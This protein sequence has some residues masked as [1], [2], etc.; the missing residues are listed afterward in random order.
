MNQWSTAKIEPIDPG[1][2]GRMDGVGALRRVIT[3][4][5]ASTRLIE[6]VRVSEP[7]HRFVYVVFEGAPALR[8]HRGEITLR[9]NGAATEL[10]W[11]V[12]MDFV[13]LG[14]A[15]IAQRSIGPELARSIATLAR[16][17][18]GG[19]AESMPT[20]R[21]PDPIDLAPLRA[22]ADR[23]LAEQRAIADRLAGAGDP[24]QWFARVYALVTEEQL[25]FLDRGEV[26]HPEWALRLVPRFH[27]YFVAPLEGFER[28]AQ[29]D[30]AWQK[31]WSVCA[32]ARDARTIVEGLLLGVAA[33][34]ETDLPRALAEV[35]RDHFRDRCEYVRFRA[36]Y[37]RMAPVF[38]IAS[39]RL[40]EQMPRG[41]LPTWLRVARAAV[42]P[43]IGGE[44]MRR[45][46]DVPKRRL[47]AFAKGADLARG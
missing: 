3:P 10:R 40:V 17:A 22:E 13:V 14:L 6:V 32:R 7:P 19:A 42:P 44:L 24:R 46:Y 1:D 20:F 26:D 31:A 18:A 41:F 11:R 45:Y 43:E 25:A 28:G 35:W 2:R 21:A 16:L 12:Q 29:I 36:D 33:H 37:V 8:V 39:D 47:K 4:G 5:I 38:R 23:V 15:T 30:P 9:E 34:I 27:R